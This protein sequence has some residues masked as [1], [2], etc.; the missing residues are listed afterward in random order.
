MQHW[1]RLFQTMPQIA[2][3]K[4]AS[5]ASAWPP[6]SSSYVVVLVLGSFTK[7]NVEFTPL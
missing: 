1:R 5:F 6:Q 7:M 4:H 3:Q 2:T